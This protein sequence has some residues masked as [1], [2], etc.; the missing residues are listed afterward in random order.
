MAS[1]D[2]FDDSF[3]EQFLDARRVNH[4]LCYSAFGTT[5]ILCNQSVAHERVNYVYV[6]VGTYSHLLTLKVWVTGMGEA[7]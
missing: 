2:A 6:V 4:R 7:P 3:E 1:R 5:C